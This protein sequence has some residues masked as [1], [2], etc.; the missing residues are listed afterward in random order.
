LVINLQLGIAPIHLRPDFRIEGIN[1][2]LQTHLG[3]HILLSLLADS[4]PSGEEEK[5]VR[6]FVLDQLA[7]VEFIVVMVYVGLVESGIV[8]G[9][10]VLHYSEALAANYF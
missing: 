6:Q 3:I 8:D 9:R 7:L 2:V 5:L 10:T 1:S 4:A